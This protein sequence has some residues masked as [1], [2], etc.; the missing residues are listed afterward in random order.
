M[1]DK[2]GLQHME[3]STPGNGDTGPKLRTTE[4]LIS[5]IQVLG[6]LTANRCGKSTY[7]CTNY[8]DFQVCHAS[9][10]RSDVIQSQRYVNDRSEDRREPSEIQ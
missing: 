10:A 6:L 4:L 2:E 7:S 5:Q 9:S 8:T 1:G 3:T